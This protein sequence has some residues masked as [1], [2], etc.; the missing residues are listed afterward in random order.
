[1][2][3]QQIELNIVESTL[4][5][6]LILETPKQIYLDFKANTDKNNSKVNLIQT[7]KLSID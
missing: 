7:L 6:R 3:K 1:M 4:R 2:I 5:T